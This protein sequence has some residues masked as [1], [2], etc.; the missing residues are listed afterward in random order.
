MTLT[1]IVLTLFL[2]F[3]LSRVILRYQSKEVSFRGL[4]FWTCVFGLAI[5]AELFPNITT[6]IAKMLGITRG[7][8]AVVYTSI[9]LLFYLVFRLY[10]YLEDIRKEITALIRMIAI[11]DKSS[12]DHKKSS[13]N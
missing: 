4:I 12:H 11:K 7:V 13:Q 6:E 3:A 8:D 2:I 9:A 5:I 10:V 1:Q